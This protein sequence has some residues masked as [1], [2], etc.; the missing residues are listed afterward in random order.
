MAQKEAT[1]QSAQADIVLPNGTVLIKNV[2]ATLLLGFET[3]LT[4]LR[5]MYDAIPT[6][7]PGVEWVEDPQASMQGVYKATKDEMGLKTEKDF[8]FRILV[9]PTPEHPAQVEKWTADK[10]V[11]EYKRVRISGM[12]TPKQK[13]DL[14]GRLDTLIGSIKKARMR[15]NTQEVKDFSIGKVIFDYLHQ[16]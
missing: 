8:N 11:G 9:K 13:S 10:P 12:L 5:E 4:K 6:L 7:Q 1:N 3:K 2:P 16:K 15:A 14:L